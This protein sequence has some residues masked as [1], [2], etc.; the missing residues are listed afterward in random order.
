MFYSRSQKSTKSDVATGGLCCISTARA[1][2]LGTVLS[3]AE[4]AILK[5]ICF[6]EL[7]G[8]GVDDWWSQGPVIDDIRKT[9]GRLTKIAKTI[10]NRR[11]AGRAVIQ[12]LWQNVFHCIL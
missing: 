6:L 11:V 5:M 2:S 4:N 12:T 8:C 1:S 7:K 9:I 10:Q 3:G